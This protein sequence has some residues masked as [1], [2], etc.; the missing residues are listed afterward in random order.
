[1]NIFLLLRLEIVK[2]PIFNLLV[3]LL[4]IIPGSNLGWAIIALTLIIRLLLVRNAMA[5]TNM[6]KSMGS[7]Q[8]KMQEIQEKHADDPQKMSAEMMNLFK[9]SG[10]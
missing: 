6:Q 7:F 1:M 9:S 8:P 4:A 10:G 5:A 3:V 2:R